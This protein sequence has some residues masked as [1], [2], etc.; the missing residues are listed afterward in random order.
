MV[1]LTSPVW[2]RRTSLPHMAK[3]RLQSSL[4][5]IASS[6]SDGQREEK[7]ISPQTK[8]PSF[9]LKLR[10]C[11][12][13]SHQLSCSLNSWHILSES[14]GFSSCC[15]CQQI[16]AMF[17]SAC[18]WLNEQCTSVTWNFDSYVHSECVAMKNCLREKRQ[19]SNSP[20]REQ[21]SGRTPHFDSLLS[22]INAT[23]N[24]AEVLILTEMGRVSFHFKC[25]YNNSDV[26]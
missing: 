22:Y 12:Y 2:L 4:P 9:D 11:Y 10:T 17:C 1:K 13:L 8:L 20:C 26:L 16:N 19:H 5:L 23:H 15:L 14:A 24:M 6:N 21:T 18:V 7:S 25:R 3:A